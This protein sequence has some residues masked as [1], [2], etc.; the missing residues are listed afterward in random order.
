MKALS[1]EVYFD[2]KDDLLYYIDQNMKSRLMISKAL[3][4]EIFE[5]IH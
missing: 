4:K 3:K 1:W 5:L 2:I